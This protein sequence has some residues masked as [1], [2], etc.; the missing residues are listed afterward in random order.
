MFEVIIKYAKQILSLFTGLV[1]LISGN[2]ND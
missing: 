1:S 2:K